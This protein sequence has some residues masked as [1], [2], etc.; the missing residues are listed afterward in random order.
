MFGRDK[1]DEEDS[2]LGSLSTGSALSGTD[3][4]LTL[5]L[6]EGYA[7]SAP[8]A[9]PP[10]VIAPGAKVVVSSP[11]DGANIRQNPT[12]GAPAVTAVNNGTILA[13]TGASKDA[14]GY[15]WWPVQGD[16]FSGWVAG[17]LIE[18]AP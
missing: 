11:G 6:P 1:K 12:L 2:G 16:G 15:T 18:P 14:D 13:I 5:G 17:T 10:G 7:G 4:P 9:P 3:E 8:P